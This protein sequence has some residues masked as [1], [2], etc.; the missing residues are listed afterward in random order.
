MICTAVNITQKLQKI[1][2]IYCH[3]SFYFLLL[4]GPLDLKKKLKQLKQNIQCKQ[5]LASGR[6]KLLAGE[7][8]GSYIATMQTLNL[9][10]Q[11]LPK[12]SFTL[13]DTYYI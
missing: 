10:H 12:I 11:F 9:F 6:C 8:K 7:S 1:I 4:T 2:Q 13:P 3:N 5:N